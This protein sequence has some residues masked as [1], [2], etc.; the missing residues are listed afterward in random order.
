MQRGYMGFVISAMD[1][2]S[3]VDPVAGVVEVY[4]GNADGDPRNDPIITGISMEFPDII[5]GR[6]AL[7]NPT[8]GSAIAINSSMLQGFV[9]V[10]TPGTIGIDEAISLGTDG[11]WDSIF[12]VPV[13][14]FYNCDADLL[15]QFPSTDDPGQGLKIDSWEIMITDFIGWNIV[16]DDTNADAIG[17]TLYNAVGSASGLYWGR[18]NENP[19]IPSETLLITVFPANSGVF[20]IPHSPPCFYQSTN[21]SIF[22][23]DDNEFAMSTPMPSPEVGR[24]IFD[25]AGI[26]V[27]AISGECRIVVQHQCSASLT[28][29]QETMLTFTRSSRQTPG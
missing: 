3:W 15:D 2:F 28:P 1:I 18:Y 12:D 27:P 25:P 5:F 21:M 17:D 19:A 14:Y 20:P 10:F 6:T 24:I 11:G 16:T 22:C 13:P 26:A 29:R 4:G 9:N 7:L 23:Y 8:A